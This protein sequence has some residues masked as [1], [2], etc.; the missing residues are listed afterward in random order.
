MKILILGG[1]AEARELAN[2]LVAAG[3]DIITSL[4]GRTHDPKLPPGKIRIGGFGGVAGLRDYLLFERIERLLDATHPYAGQMSAH[5][6]AAAEISGVP[7]VRY[8]RPAW[9]PQ[10][11]ATWLQVDSVAEAAA[12]LPDAARV[13]L[14]TGHA[15]LA[16]FMARDDCRFIV[17]TIEAPSLPLPANATLLQTR[18][19]HSLD[20]ERD[21]LAREHITHL[22][23]KNSGGSQTAAKLEAARDL[24]VAVIMIARPPY[25]AATEVD[26]LDAAIA[27]ILGG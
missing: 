11:G 6:V 22:V 17:R 23:T 25:A 10:P 12:S 21:L 15:G 4:A 13:L 14:T 1:T 24:G 16:L 20:E 7:L 8:M 27:A 9:E 2:R 26:S 3:H 5:A 19:P 18:P